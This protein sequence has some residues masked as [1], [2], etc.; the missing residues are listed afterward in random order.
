MAMAHGTRNRSTLT[1]TVITLVLVL[2][3]CINPFQ[4]SD[5]EGQRDRAAFSGYATLR[6]NSGGVG[7]AT[8]APDLAALK[9]Q[10]SSYTL[11]L[12]NDAPGTYEPIVISDY[13]EGTPITGIPAPSE[14]T[15]SVQGFNASAQL[16]A[17]GT[18]VGGNPISFADAT[19]LDVDVRLQPLTTG[20]GEL[21]F[22]VDWSG[23]VAP[24]IVVD[25]VEVSLFSFATAV[26]ESVI[27]SV[28]NESITFTNPDVSTTANAAVNFAAE[29]VT[30]TDA[31]LRSGTYRIGITPIKIDGG[32]IPYAPTIEAVQI[33]DNLLSSGSVALSPGDLTSPPSAPTGIV[34]EI[35]AENTFNLL[36]TDNSNNEEGFRVFEDDGLGTRL[37]L[38]PDHPAG[39]D[40]LTNQVS[41]F[42]LPVDDFTVEV[43]AYNRF[44]ESVP[45][46]FTFRLLQTAQFPSFVN[47]GNTN[48]ALWAAPG[49]PGSIN[50]ST[51]IVGGGSAVNLY[52]DTGDISD[53]IALPA[54]V[55]LAAP[56]YDLAVLGPFAPG[57]G[58]NWRVE[59]VGDVGNEGRVIYPVETVAMRDGNLYVATT[60]SV[61][62]AGS[63][64]APLAGIQEAIALAESGETINIA[65][66]SYSETGGVTVD[67][68]VT[69]EGSWDP[70]FSFQDL[71]T[72]LTTV[73]SPTPVDGS[74]VTVTGVGTTAQLRNLRIELDNPSVATN[75]S[76]VTVTT[77]A[78]AAIEQS[79]I[80][81][82]QSAGAF[83]YAIR[84]NNSAGNVT[85]RG[86]E[87]QAAETAGVQTAEGISIA[88]TYTGAV[89]VGGPAPADGNT[90]LAT[91]GPDSIHHIRVSTG[92]AATAPSIIVQN[93]TF[94]SISGTGD[95][96]QHSIYAQSDE[97]NLEIADNVFF[98]HTNAA[99]NSLWAIRIQ[100]DGDVTVRNNRFA[101]TLDTD[102]PV[103]AI[104]IE[105]GTGA[106]STTINA[107]KVQ[108]AGANSQTNTGIRVL[109]TALISNNIVVQEGTSPTT[110][111]FQGVESEGENTKILHNIF[112]DQNTSV[113]GNLVR[114]PAGNNQIVTNNIFLG[115][116]AGP[117]DG[118]GLF[119]SDTALVAEVNSNLFFGLTWVIEN[120]T[121]GAFADP[122]VTN[123]NARAFAAGN[124]ADDPIL[125]S[126][127]V[128]ADATWY[129]PGIL[130]TGDNY[131]VDVP[132]DI[133]GTVRTD[134][135]VIGA[136]QN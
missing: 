14:W 123:L 122:A 58:Y 10:I 53:P 19:P 9:G 130:P 41:T 107:N 59:T 81:V 136:Y 33:Y 96:W 34:V 62:A 63:T 120:D 76:A 20:T 48:S 95:N 27:L 65:A 112:Y 60:G 16:V 124:I 26:E 31:S 38:G 97:A 15:L 4:D 29:T 43:V 7:A 90:F 85:I 35:T 71:G 50:W 36:W 113:L 132:E 105:A 88:G 47:S 77:G 119:I 70:T 61:G 104:E 44:G 49:N 5:R 91:G 108:M 1:A 66:G 73:T 11:S 72:Q 46:T 45:A 13:L 94:E 106:G 18:P 78:D 37:Q 127:S 100:S 87:I 82:V 131:L 83:S 8:I 115:P 57:A 52:L 125:D 101:M 56:P 134:P 133:N 68:T 30:I 102:S 135:P 74:T 80:V 103:T 92:A 110:G 75:Y 22:A 39:T 12:T 51:M 114:L 17:E 129:K 118:R 79:R 40:G 89:T 2:S 69:I 93:N 28:G 126:V 42:T 25:A 99:T 55:A 98:G 54:P 24:G 64:G 23:A 117:N 67:Q 6:V 84:V 116:D 3:S 111:V 109:R 86:N 32:N 21:E 128:I 121:G